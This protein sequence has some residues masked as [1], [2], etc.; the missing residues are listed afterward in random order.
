MTRGMYANRG[1]TAKRF[2][3]NRRMNAGKLHPCQMRG[4]HS[5]GLPIARSSRAA[6]SPLPRELR[7]ADGHLQAVDAVLAGDEQRLAVLAAEAGVGSELLDGDQ[8]QRLA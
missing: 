6:A 5:G 3:H 1:W 7:A 4:V 8:A 2:F